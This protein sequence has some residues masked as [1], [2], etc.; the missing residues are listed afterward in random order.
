MAL[1]C[2]GLEESA[3]S[4]GIDR[5][6]MKVSD[7][8]V[9]LLRAVAAANP[10]TVVLLSAGA[11]VE[12][13]WTT[14]AK[15]LL[16]L[17][18]GGQAGAGAALDVLMGRVNPS[19]KTAETWYRHLSDNPTAGNFPS[20]EKT[21]EYREGL[22]V[23]YRYCQT[24]GVRPAFPFGFGLSY[25]TFAYANLRVERDATCV[26]RG[27][28]CPSPSPTPVPSPVPRSCSSM[29]P[30]PA[31][32]VPSRAGAQGLCQGVPAA[33]R[34]ARVTLALG[35]TGLSL[36]ECGHGRLGGRGRHL[37]AARG[38]GERRRSPDRT[39]SSSTAP[40]PPIPYAGLDLAPYETGRSQRPP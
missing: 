3:E 34:V 16:H 35:D 30:S 19:G 18:L 17:A 2:L 26:A 37:R 20:Y 22:Y 23:G 40:A 4:E 25:T 39:P 11:S 29:W 13:E 28:R 21:A 24:A 6:N 5:L 10:N 8:Q 38:S 7:A 9:A 36:L 15:A 1:V 31:R 12:T 14:D 32:G 33:G 27:P